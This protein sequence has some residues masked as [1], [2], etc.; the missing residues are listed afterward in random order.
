MKPL[1]ARTRCYAWLLPASPWGHA[2]ARPGMPPESAKRELARTRIRLAL[3]VIERAALGP[4]EADATEP[5]G[6]VGSATPT[7]T[8]PESGYSTISTPCIVETQ[9]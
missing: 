1:S 8:F 9:R 6:L 3:P 2:A 4:E 5:T 7:P